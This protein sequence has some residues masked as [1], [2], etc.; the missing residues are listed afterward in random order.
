MGTSGE[1]TTT[2]FGHVVVGGSVLALSQQTP[3]G[4]TDDYALGPAHWTRQLRRLTRAGFAHVDLIDGWLPVPTMSRT[5]LETLGGV[6]ADVGVQPLGLNISRH[7]LVDPMRGLEHLEYSIQAVDAA[8]AL[9]I[10]LIGVGFHPRLVPEQR[11]TRM[12]WEVE[13]PPDDRSDATWA[14]A[15]ERLGELCSY[16]E[17]RQVQV[18]IEIYEDSLVCTA[19]DMDRIITSVGAPNLGINPD[20]GNTF[21]SVTP[22]R[23]SWLETIRG[24][25]PHMDFWHVKNY[26]RSS[27]G[28]SGPF[29]VAP[30]TVGMGGIDYRL[31]VSE[32][33]AGGFAG[34]LV[35]EH[36]GGD[37]VEMQRLGREYLVRLVDELMEEENA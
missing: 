22:Q 23:E 28:P 37:A 33:L 25:I 20:L 16:A 9:G 10:P 24:A 36:Y 29:A 27:L 7:S 5:E 34:P 3:G 4:R 17:Q 13:V 19:A 14:L 35:V 31:A 30:T 26:T 12:F 15:A 21:R 32:V 2:R 11:H 18:S 6:L 1:P 8:E